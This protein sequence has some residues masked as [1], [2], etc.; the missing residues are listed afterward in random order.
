MAAC[1]ILVSDPPAPAGS[2]QWIITVE[3]MSREPATLF[4]ALDESP[5]GRRVGTALPSTVNAGV[6]QRVVFTVPPGQGW[7]IFVNPS[8]VRGPLI[9]AQ[10][11]P[12]NFGGEFPGTIHIGANGDPALSTE[13][14]LG[15]GWF[16]N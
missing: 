5:M 15:P 12:P 14:N 2:R 13:G 11:V 9:L 4:V 3:N 10:D 7:A 16:G 6:T 8:P 1:S